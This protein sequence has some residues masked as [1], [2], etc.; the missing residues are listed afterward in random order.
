MA[1]TMGPEIK[2]IRWVGS[3]S[4]GPAW[5]DNAKSQTIELTPEIIKTY[6]A[7][8]STETL[9]AGELFLGLQKGLPYQFQ[10]QLGLAL[11]AA[12]NAE[13]SGD[14]WDDADPQFNNFVYSYKIKHSHIALKGKLLA[15]RGFWVIPWI[16]GSVG[17]GFN[18]A[19]DFHSTPTIFEALPVPDFISHTKTAFSYTLGAGIQKALGSNFQIGVGYEFADW[20]KSEL[21]RAMGQTLNTGLRLNH[22]YTNGV[23]FNISYVG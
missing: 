12:G 7:R 3:V 22:L 19:Y 2:T 18:K 21:G 17:V 9:A 4:A 13:L 1:G 8:K 16:S 23:M 14:V 5:A 6:A 10:G 11:A 20:G 15:D